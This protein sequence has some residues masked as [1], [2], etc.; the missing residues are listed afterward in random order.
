ME[1]VNWKNNSGHLEKLGIHPVIYAITECD[2]CNSEIAEAFTLPSKDCYKLVCY[3]CMNDNCDIDIQLP[4]GSFFH[5]KTFD[6][7]Y[8]VS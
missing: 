1:N 2:C 4:D 3:S 6:W 7:K 8:F 5:T